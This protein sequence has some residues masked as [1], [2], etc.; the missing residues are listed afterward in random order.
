MCVRQV[1]GTL[2]SADFPHLHGRYKGSRRGRGLPAE[3]VHPGP[4]ELVPVPGEGPVLDL[5]HADRPER[6]VLSPTTDVPPPTVRID[7]ER[8]ALSESG[9]SEPES[10]GR[11]LPPRA[12]RTAPAG[13]G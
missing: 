7:R 9:G 13:D 5:A 6:R 4:G 3:D 12:P 2:Q 11:V 10:R 1:S 8:S